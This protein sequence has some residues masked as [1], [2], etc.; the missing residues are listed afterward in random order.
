M[1]VRMVVALLS[2]PTAKS[3]KTSEKGPG[4]RSLG[5]PD[6]VGRPMQTNGGWC[7]MSIDFAA[8]CLP[9]AVRS[10]AA[11]KG[12][13]RLENAYEPPGIHVTIFSTARKCIESWQR[14]CVMR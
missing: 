11:P 5:F 3:A 6:A 9:N 12:T 10:A 8:A 1:M 13:P 14:N 2:L 4:T 7:I